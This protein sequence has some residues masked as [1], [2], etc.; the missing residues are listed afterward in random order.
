MAKHKKET[1]EEVFDRRQWQVKAIEVFF[2]ILKTHKEITADTFYEKCREVEMPPK[3]IAEI[4]G[5][6]IK[7]M[8]Y[9]GYLNKT[10]EFRLS[11]R[12]SRPLP[13]Y[14]IMEGLTK[15]R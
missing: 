6:L 15:N 1:V 12:T 7:S 13:V 9:S 4:S 5:G 2:G 14:K 11:E 10:K 8:L 3:L